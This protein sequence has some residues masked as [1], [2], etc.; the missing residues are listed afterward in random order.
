MEDVAVASGSIG[1]TVPSDVPPPPGTQVDPSQAVLSQD[2]L[3]F[4]LWLSEGDKDGTKGHPVDNCLLSAR[5]SRSPACVSARPSEAASE[6]RLCPSSWT[7]DGLITSRSLCPLKVVSG[8]RGPVKEDA[9]ELGLSCH[10]TRQDTFRGGVSLE[11]TGQRPRLPRRSRSRPRPP[12]PH[13]QDWLTT[14]AGDL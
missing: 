9:S 3:L 12:V 13:L 5:P 10:V 7:K 8:T 14:E 6:D 2:A 11:T 4:T 1:G